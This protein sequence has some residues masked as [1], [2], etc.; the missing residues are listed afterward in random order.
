MPRESA[1]PSSQPDVSEQRNTQRAFHLPGL[2]QL[3]RLNVA[4]RGSERSEHETGDEACTEHAEG[5]RCDGTPRL[6]DRPEHDVAILERCP[7]GIE[8]QARAFD[9]VR[10]VI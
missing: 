2:D 7:R 8:L 6:P 5:F 9:A 1:R 10:K 3:A 4:Q